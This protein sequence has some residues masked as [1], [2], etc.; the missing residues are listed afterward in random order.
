MQTYKNVAESQGLEAAKL[1]SIDLSIFKSLGYQCCNSILTWWLDSYLCSQSAD[2]LN[3]RL[4]VAYLNTCF[5]Q[6]LFEVSTLSLT[7][8]N[9]E[10]K[11]LELQSNLDVRD[12]TAALDL[13]FECWLLSDYSDGLKRD[14]MELNLIV[15]KAIKKVIQSLNQSGI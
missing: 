14:D 4:K 1:S 3:S 11:L 12:S 7:K 13:L 8:L 9:T 6:N 15:Y 5:L 2:D 10:K